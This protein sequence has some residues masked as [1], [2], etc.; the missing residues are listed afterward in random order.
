MNSHHFLQQVNAYCYLYEARVQEFL[1]G[2]ETAEIDD[3]RA[4]IAIIEHPLAVV[5]YPMQQEPPTIDL[6]T[7]EVRP[8]G[9]RLMLPAEAEAMLE[10]G[11]RGL[12][13]TRHG[14]QDSLV[15][16]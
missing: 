9:H 4:S 8:G 7:H 12:K 14:E 3:G 5:S 2:Q 11:R 15:P 13:L 10:A 1:L 6:A 16:A